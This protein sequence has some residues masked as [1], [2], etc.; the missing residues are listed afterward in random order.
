MVSDARPLPMEPKMKFESREVT[1]ALAVGYTT[2][3]ASG[4]STSGT[5]GR[6]SL[7]AAPEGPAAFEGAVS[8]G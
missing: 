8:G 5:G 2:R 4:P 1:T 3:M 7:G 6:G